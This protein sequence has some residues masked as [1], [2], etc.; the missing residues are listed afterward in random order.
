MFA[1]DSTELETPDRELRLEDGL[2]MDKDAEPGGFVEQPIESV[3]FG[4]IA[5]QQAK[6]VMVQKVREAERAQVIE[7]FPGPRQHAG[8]WRGQ[9]RGS[10]WCIR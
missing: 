4:R 3:V 1:D 2:D 7:Q 6:Q 5:A 9:A 10:Q 8:E